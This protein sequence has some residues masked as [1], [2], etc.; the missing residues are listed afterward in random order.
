MR[1]EVVRSI[2]SRVRRWCRNIDE[3]LARLAPAAPD[4]TDDDG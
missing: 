2:P 3:E 1:E 4:R